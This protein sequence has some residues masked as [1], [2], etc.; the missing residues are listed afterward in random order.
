MS[1]NEIMDE[2]YKIA[3][4]TG[5]IQSDFGHHPLGN[6]DD[7][8]EVKTRSEPTEDYGLKIDPQDIIDE[9]HPKPAWI[10]ENSPRVPG[11]GNGSLVENLK[12]QQEADLKILDK[13]PSG[14]LIGV[15]AKL[16]NE[17]I[18]IANE[19]EDAGKIKYAKRIDATISKILPFCDISSH[20]KAKEAA[21]PLFLIPLGLA[22]TGGTYGGLKMFGAELTSRQENLTVDLKDLFEK[23]K[24]NEELSKS[25]SKAATLIEPFIDKLEE[26][27]MS[28]KEGF[29]EYKKI[30]ND[31]SPVLKEV[32]VLVLAA[33]QDIQE[34]E[35]FFSKIWG[36]IKDLFGF[37]EYKLIAAKYKDVMASYEEV[38]KFIK[39]A[40]KHEKN[41]LKYKKDNGFIFKG[42]TYNNLEELE[43]Q[44][45]DALK[46]LYEQ[47]KFQKQY[48]VNI[49]ENGTLIGTP[50]RL[51]K[52][53]EIIEN[54]LSA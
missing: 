8:T 48:S 11:A 44:L 34:P 21:F 9:A 16:I 19:L 32:G 4:E 7:I 29:E 47:N 14:A 15:H 45:N 22:L 10:D 42:K 52:V 30:L 5:L 26:S 17:L 46:T 49:V 23:L 6:L 35:G 18:K 51:K 36:E 53:I 41:I 31:L 39:E 43:Q 13:M 12:E 54:Q 37:E 27:N 20:K 33:Q 2:F 38:K 50:E 25:A 28:T 3:K 40:E 1:S 24:E